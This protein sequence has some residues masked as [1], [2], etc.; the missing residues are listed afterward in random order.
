VKNC[1]ERLSQI[2]A[3]HHLNVAAAMGGHVW[4]KGFLRLAECQR[5]PVTEFEIL[6]SHF[7]LKSPKKCNKL[8]QIQPHTY[9]RDDKPTMHTEEVLVSTGEHS[10]HAVTSLSSSWLF[11]LFQCKLLW[12]G[13][14]SEHW[15][16]QMR[17][18]SLTV[19]SSGSQAQITFLALHLNPLSMLQN[20]LNLFKWMGKI[21]SVWCKWVQCLVM[22]EL[23][24]IRISSLE[25]LIF[26]SLQLEYK[27]VL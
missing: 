7:G 20:L 6:I 21:C 9:L 23:K 16:S 12:D 27:A 10:N 26:A 25:S 19:C 5:P 15:R 18:N 14:A 4:A 17:S 3:H 13:P 24:Q 22:D 11:S 2:A 8:R 1:A